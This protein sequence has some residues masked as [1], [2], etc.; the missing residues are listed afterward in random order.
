MTSQSITGPV[1]NVTVDVAK[2]IG[3]ILVVLGHNWI[4]QHEDGELRRIIY[5]FHMPLFILIS[6]I[7][8]KETAFFGEF[9][10]HKAR[11]LLKPYLSTV[12]IMGVL[13]VIGGVPTTGYLV[14]A[15]YGTGESF[16][17]GAHWTM[18]PLWFLPCL[19]VTF[20]VTWKIIRISKVFGFSKA[21]MLLVVVTLLAFGTKYLGAFW[22]VAIPG[23]GQAELP[24]EGKG[25]PGLPFSVDLVVLC[26]GF[27]LA[28]YVLREEIQTMTFNG[29]RLAVVTILFSGLHY[30]FDHFIDLNKRY[31]G[32]WP[33]VM[34]QVILGIYIAISLARLISRYRLPARILGYI[35]S[36]SLFILLFHQ[37]L[38][39]IATV[40]LSPHLRSMYGVGLV[41][42]LVGISLPLGIFEV[43]KRHKAIAHLFLPVTCG[44][45]KSSTA[46]TTKNCR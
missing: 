34:L 28:G 13:L 31:L 18:E 6:G 38:Q 20:L 29:F 10:L 11:S 3:I 45:D 42:L 8:L 37:P 32:S 16:R 23:V 7:Y 36:A 40:N 25:L 30:R 39:Y 26:S 15:L 14:A 2:G 44:P 22:H 24:G 17:A 12:T 27:M 21:G 43:A 19:F 9:C 1:R 4:V 33:I 35:G 41:A 5:S 46:K